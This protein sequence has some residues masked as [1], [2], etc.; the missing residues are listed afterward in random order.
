[1]LVDVYYDVIK[2]KQKKIH[3]AYFLFAFSKLT[4]SFKIKKNV[5]NFNIQKDALVK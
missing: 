1:M 5:N 2:S 4:Q 3:V